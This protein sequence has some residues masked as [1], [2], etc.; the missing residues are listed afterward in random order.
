VLLALAVP[1][2]RD[3]TVRAKITECIDAAAVAKIHISEYRQTLGAWPPDVTEAGI[4]GM[5]GDSHYC[6]GFS[7]YQPAT[8]AF[9]IHIDAAAINPALGDVKPL[10]VP[11]TT[12]ST[13][14]TWD[15]RLG[16]TADENAKYLPSTCRDN[17]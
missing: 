16:A 8:G 12:A 10:M 9:A 17:G 5:A 6:S 3:Y 7:D 13:F 11:S 2:Y 4:D 14:V 15:C 1:A